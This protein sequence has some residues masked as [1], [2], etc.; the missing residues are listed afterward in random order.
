MAEHTPGPWT[1]DLEHGRG[2][3]VRA[4]DGRPV[5]SLWENGDQCGYNGDLIAAAP[6]MLE[7]LQAYLEAKP[8][9]DCTDAIGCK[10]EAAR[11]LARAAIA[12]ATGA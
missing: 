10:M 9:C 3:I 6:D 4:A 8:Q 11:V 2:Y 5:A 1:S 12:K 7:A